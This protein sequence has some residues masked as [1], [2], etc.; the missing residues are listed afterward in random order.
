MRPASGTTQYFNHHFYQE[1]SDKM[2]IKILKS[3]FDFLKGTDHEPRIQKK[4]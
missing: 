4:L 1:L 3:V 2:S